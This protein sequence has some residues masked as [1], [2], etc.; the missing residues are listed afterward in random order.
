MVRL[1]PVIVLLGLTVLVFA[2]RPGPVV[3]QG[4]PIDEIFRLVNQVRAEYGLPP[5][6]YNQTLAAAA[7]GHANYLAANGYYTHYGSDGSSPQDR[8]ARA[9][10]GGWAGENYVAG[11]KLTP[12]QGVTWWRNSAPHFANMVSPRHT[13]AGVGFAFGHDQ[14]YYV[15][16]VGEPSAGAPRARPPEQLVDVAAF[17]APIEISPE[18]ED[19]SIVHT[20]Q[21]GHTLW[22]IAARYGVSIA[23][24]LLF[25]GLN[26]DSFLNPGDELVIQ[27]A[28]GQA[29][30]PTPTPPATYIVREGES[31]WAI[32]AWNQIELADL[33]WLNG[34]S[35]DTVVH[36]GNEI[37]I[38]LLPGEAPP[39]TPTPQITHKVSSGDTLWAIA[40][41]YGL[42]LQEL[43]DFNQLSE[44]TLLQVGEE[45]VI[46]PPTATPTATPPPTVTPTL[47]PGPDSAL[48]VPTQAPTRTPV[49]VAESVSP[50]P[51]PAES[52][53]GGWGRTLGIAAMIAGLGL[54]V[55]AA[56]AVMVLWRGE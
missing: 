20:V 38:R 8:A 48:L 13:E 27:L 55:L 29:P 11:T 45:L 19:G 54:T 51:D 18:R 17:V 3:A 43:L 28:E 21:S 34:F 10:Y 14:N 7:Q 12:A 35:E 31:L 47:T 53:E 25:N 44:S 32:A 40:A 16:V 2:S 52:D 1:R 42:S 30:P 56:V 5:Y 6:T 9:G 26:E 36:P 46:R 37:K 49:A 4:N 50:T 24:I 22:A 23:D 39:P 41:R 33:L 15:L